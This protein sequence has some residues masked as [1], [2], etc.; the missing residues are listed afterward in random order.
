MTKEDYK[1]LALEI[2]KKILSMHAKSKSSHI[3]SAFSCVEI[4]VTLY[5][6]ILKINP[7]NLEDNNRDRFILSKGHAC[8]ALYATL[9]KRN[10][11]SEKILDTYAINGGQLFGHITKGIVPGI[12]TSAGSLGHGLPIG[13]GI[14]ISMRY[15]KTKSRVFILMSDGECNEGSIWEGALFAAHHKLE[16]LVAIIDYN[17]LQA[18]GTTDEVI[19]LEPFVEKWESF[20]WAVKEVDGHN[21]KQLIET[22]DK[23][24][25]EK[26]KPS[27]VI[28]HTVKGKGVSFMENKLEW[29]YKSPNQEEVIAALQ[30]LELQ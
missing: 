2:R 20:G 12:E 9:A 7:K 23:V 30:E 26:D 1:K 24:P 11:F 6:K 13:I 28:A 10:F 3:G 29:H 5:F 8:S 25:F 19:G 16:N 4:L 22:L 21:F 14:A 15:D 27:M 18:F 17:K